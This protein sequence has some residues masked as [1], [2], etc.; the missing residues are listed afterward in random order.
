MLT[1]KWVGRSPCEC[2]KVVTVLGKIDVNMRYTR[3]KAEQLFK[4]QFKS[5]L[6]KQL[7]FLKETKYLR[8]IKNNKRNDHKLASSA[9]RKNANMTFL[10]PRDGILIASKQIFY[11][12][13]ILPT[14]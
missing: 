9:K 3:K 12:N 4:V 13:L 5:E 2:K 14:K 1:S 10:I 11:N 7:T 8:T 6:T